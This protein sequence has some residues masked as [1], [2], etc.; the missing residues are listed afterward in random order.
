MQEEIRCRTQEASRAPD[1]CRGMKSSELGHAKGRTPGHSVCSD[2]LYSIG[3]NQVGLRDRP[4]SDWG[5]LSG[6]V[7]RGGESPLQGE[8]PDGST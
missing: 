5:V 1:R 2:G 7:L 8:G 3:R 6:I 4:I